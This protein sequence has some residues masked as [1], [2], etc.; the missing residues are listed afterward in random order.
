MLG[1]LGPDRLFGGDGTD[2]IHDDPA[3]FGSDKSA[4]VLSGGPGDDVLVSTDTAD[5]ADRLG[6]GDGLDRAY[7]DD[8]DR[9]AADCEKVS[10][11]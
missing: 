7:V 10:R 2:E 8:G 6:C 9:V 11:T 1:G 4:D 5:A 3:E